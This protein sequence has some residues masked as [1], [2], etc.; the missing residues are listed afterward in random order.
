[1][2]QSKLSAAF[3]KEV[4]SGIPGELYAFHKYGYY[5]EKQDLRPSIFGLSIVFKLEEFFKQI[6]FRMTTSQFEYTVQ[7]FY[8]FIIYTV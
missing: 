6:Q 7:V 2:F 4:L 5:L 1:M 3:F 8:E